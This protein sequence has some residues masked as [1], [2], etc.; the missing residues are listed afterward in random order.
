LIYFFGYVKIA[1]NILFRL[2]ETL[3]LI[4]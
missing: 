2:N 4:F 1:T 3:A